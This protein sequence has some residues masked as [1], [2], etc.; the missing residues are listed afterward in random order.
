MG[1]RS[2]G[3]TGFADFL[4]ISSS[5]ARDFI[6]DHNYSDGKIKPKHAIKKL[7]RLLKDGDRYE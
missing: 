2:Y 7:K 3:V 1:I 5:E 6:Y 4:G